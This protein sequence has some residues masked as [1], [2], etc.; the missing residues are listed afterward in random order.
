MKPCSYKEHKC[1]CNCF[2][3]VRIYDYE[4]ADRYYCTLGDSESR[5]DSG[6]VAMQECHYY[7]Y[8]CDEDS[9]NTP[10]DVWLA[11]EKGREV[12]EYGYC[13]NWKQFPKT[14][15]EKYE[16]FNT[17]ADRLKEETSHL[18][19]SSQTAKNINFQRI[20]EIGYPVERFIIQR[21]R[22]GDPFHWFHALAK[23]TH[24]N[25]VPEEDQGNVPK[26][27]Q[28]WLNWWDEEERRSEEIR[29]RD[30]EYEAEKE[31]ETE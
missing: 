2:Y 16:V 12:E 6:S 8:F 28:H 20:V 9:G 31:R 24:E 15:D 11:W 14:D 17:L 7:E 21:I 5:P 29:R 1:C 22:D 18:S 10:W 25:P 23:I 19:S 3:R 26:M 27:R 13:P 4:D 30:A